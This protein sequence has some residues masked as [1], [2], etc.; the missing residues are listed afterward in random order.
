MAKTGIIVLAV[1]ISADAAHA[2]TTRKPLRD[3]GVPVVR[4]SAEHVRWSIG[5]GDS[6]E[7]PYVPFPEDL[8]ARALDG[9]TVD[10]RGTAAVTSVKDQGPHGYCG[11]FGRV[12]SAEG[13]YGV[14]SGYGARNFSVQQLIDCVGWDLDQTPSFETVGFMDYEDYPYNLTA[15][16]D[17]DPPIPGNPCRLDE[18]KIIP[19]SVA[20]NHTS[21]PA[22]EGEASFAAGVFAWGPLQAGIN[23]DVFGARD[24]NNFVS[25]DACA[26]FDGT[27]IDHSV[28]LVGYGVDE[29]RG[30]YWIIKNS[31]AETFADN[32]FVYVARNVNCGS[33]LEADVG[34]Y[35]YGGAETYYPWAV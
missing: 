32:G 16:P 8:V 9:R 21:V 24:D 26:E 34:L 23:A 35:T 6:A 13:Q 10:W 29:A 18:S 28:L 19:G 14:R 25:A 2:H 15:Y 33:I 30:E 17:S 31:W 27:D 22:S 11:T 5:A 20:W 4:M 7:L 1:V 12:E 3:D